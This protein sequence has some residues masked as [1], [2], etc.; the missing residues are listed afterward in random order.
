M[1]AFLSLIIAVLLSALISGFI[2][3]IVSKL[4][5]GLHVDSF[6]WAMLAGLLIGVINS[7]VMQ[8]VPGTTGIIHFVVSLL[9]SAAV[10]FACGAM[11][12]GLTVK[13]YVGALIAAV[14]ISAVG[15]L[16]LLVLVGGA[17]VIEQATNP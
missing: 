2:I 9:V 7:L 14:A 6:G 3:W 1:E 13:G 10:I 12:K 17:T 5:L 11:L 15:I 16:L 4:N 8:F